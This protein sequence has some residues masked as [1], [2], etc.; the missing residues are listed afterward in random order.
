MIRTPAVR[1]AFLTAAI[2]LSCACSGWQRYEVCFGMSIDGGK[3]T[4]SG[5]EWSA[6]V[7]REIAPRFP[8]GFTIIEASG[9]WRDASGR[10]YSEP[11]RVLLLVSPRG[12]GAD[13][14]LDALMDAYKQRFRQECVLEVRSPARVLFR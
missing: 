6:F 2:A 8:D 5:A 4:V 9:H 10:T 11:S 13:E 14:R 7:E 12:V 3:A 1:I